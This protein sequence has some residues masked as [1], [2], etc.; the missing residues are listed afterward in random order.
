MQGSSLKDIKRKNKEEQYY[1]MFPHK[2]HSMS[3]REQMEAAKQEKKMCSNCTYFL[4]FFNGT[5]WM[6][7]GCQHNPYKRKKKEWL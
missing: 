2:R 4:S 6:C 1:Q 3:E 7:W 5:N